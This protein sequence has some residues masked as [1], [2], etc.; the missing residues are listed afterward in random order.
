MQP[1][2]LGVMFQM[3]A[4]FYRL[5]FVAVPLRTDFSLDTD[6]FDTSDANFNASRSLFLSSIDIF[7]RSTHK[8]LKANV[9]ADST[10]ASQGSQSSVFFFAGFFGV[11]GFTI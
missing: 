1:L 8:K 7:N 4:L 6:A 11:E 2:G 5:K 3:H 10:N 9:N